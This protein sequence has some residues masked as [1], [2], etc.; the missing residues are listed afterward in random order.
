MTSIPVVAPS[1]ATLGLTILRIIVGIVFLAHGSQKLFVFGIHGVVGAFGQMGVPLPSIVGPLI[2]IL[3]FV[4]GIC[5]VLGLFT[6]IFAALLACDMLGAI[7]L[8]HLRNGF[9]LPNG[10]EFPFTLLGACVALAIAGAGDYAIDARRT[11][12]V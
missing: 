2:A 5:L 11:R 3:E 1:R 10:F 7:L 8:V 12:E 4:G 6:R 9:F